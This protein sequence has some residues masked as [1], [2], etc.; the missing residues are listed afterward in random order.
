MDQNKTRMPT[1]PP[2]PRTYPINPNLIQGYQAPFPIAQNC[3][4]LG[5]YPKLGYWELLAPALFGVAGALLLSLLPEKSHLIDRYGGT[6]FKLAIVGYSIGAT[7]AVSFA[8][9]D[10]LKESKAPHDSLL[11]PIFGALVTIILLFAADYLLL[12]RFFPSSFEGNNVGDDVWTQAFSFLYLS[13][14]TIPGASL[15]DILPNNVTA[16]ALIATEIAFYLF[17]MATAIQLLLA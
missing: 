6:F 3:T 10:V 17:T 5:S 11:L 2:Y 14:T 1:Y 12:Y 16:R 7:L 13:V 9:T 8:I 4:P 15:G